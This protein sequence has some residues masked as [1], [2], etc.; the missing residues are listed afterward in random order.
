MN[1]SVQLRNLL[2]QNKAILLIGA[3]DGL[4][5]KLAEKNGFDAV[6]ASGFEIAAS[7]AVPDANILTMSQNLER[8]CEINDAIDIPVIADCDT[9]FGNS[10][11]VI[12]LVKKYE[13]AGIA[14]VCIEDKKFPK[15]NSFIDG[16]QEL[17]PVA[18]FV[19]KIMAA[20]SNQVSDDFMV[21]ARV[22]ALIAGRSMNEAIERAD[23]YVKAGADAILIHSKERDQGEIVEFCKLWKKRSPLVIVPTKYPDFSEK[24]LKQMGIKV[25][26]YA[27]HGIRAAAKAM[28]EALAV[29]M[30]DR[31]K[32]KIENSIAT[33]DFMF[34][35]QGMDKMKQ[36]EKVYL[37]TE[38]E[39]VDVVILA[40]GKPNYQKGL[41]KLLVDL[42]PV[43]LDI[44]GKTL[45]QRNVEVLNSLGINNIYVVTGYLEDR[46]DAKGIKKIINRHFEQGYILDSFMQAERFLSGRVLFCYGDV[47]FDKSIIENL[48]KRNEEITLVVDPSFK[49]S[50]TGAH[51]LDLVRTKQ[52]TVV[53]TRSFEKKSNPVVEIST[54]IAMEKAD[55]E[56]IGLALFS[57]TGFK[58]FVHQYQAAKLKYENKSFQT[59]E[60]FKKASFAD[61]L[62]E[63]IN[64]GYYVDTMEV[65]SG[66]IEVHTFENYKLASQ[67]LETI[68]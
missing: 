49:K 65:R 1:K 47:M 54:K 43:M 10:N 45:L 22:E 26:I 62:N 68:K 58:D 61:M 7:F 18:E 50:T 27:N 57:K 25:V 8:A 63:M 16:R 9:G 19:G 67:M 46:V 32:D 48:L 15:V 60:S 2:K 51:T 24:D 34:Q 23:A 5:A 35:L 20:K 31:S 40:A 13:A 30:R 64:N 66:W 37:K 3:H 44:N 6:W 21:I 12:H 28:D 53:S 39:D 52:A 14:A 59:A 11:N 17:A 55:Y 41:M 38:H 36:E 4:S 56:F 29:I 42:P 33:M